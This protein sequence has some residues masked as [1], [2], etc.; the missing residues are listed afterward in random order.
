MTDM[1]DPPHPGE[2]IQV[3]ITDLGWTVVETAKRIG[4]T[5]GTLSR[6]LN[7]HASVTPKTALALERLGWSDAGHWARMQS[8]Y[9]VAKARRD[10]ARSRSRVRSVSRG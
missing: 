10:Q 7:G 6:I 4:C 3:A 2:I 5:R 8:A 9:D 1:Y